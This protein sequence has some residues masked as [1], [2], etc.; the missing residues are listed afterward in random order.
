MFR[1]GPE[2]DTDNTRVDTDNARHVHN[3]VGEPSLDGAVD[4]PL[5]VGHG[6]Y[7]DSERVTKL[8]PNR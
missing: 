7:A 6:K 5:A 4:R 8:P 2:V 3:D 1:Y